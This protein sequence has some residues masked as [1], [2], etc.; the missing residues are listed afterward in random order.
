MTTLEKDFQMKKAEEKINVKDLQ[1]LLKKS[2]DDQSIQ[3]VKYA[4]S[5]FV[6]LGENYGSTM[7]K[8]DLVIERSTCIKNDELNLIAKTKAPSERPLVM[9]N[10]ALE[11]EVFIYDELLP[12]YRDLEREVGVPE[13]DLINFFP[14]YYGHRFLLNE[15]SDEINDDSLF[16]ME[17][18]KIRE[19]TTGNRQ[20]GKFKKK[21]II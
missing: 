14:K 13:S 5:L 10:K 6:P 2:F 12:A 9:W 8:L 7:V 19:Y 1:S 3:I 18:L 11:K 4:S 21:S 15:N 17:N 16:L 20:I